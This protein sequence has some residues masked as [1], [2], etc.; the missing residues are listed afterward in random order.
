[1]K[2]DT[3]ARDTRIFMATDAFRTLIG[4]VAKQRRDAE[5]YLC[6]Q[7]PASI[8]PARITMERQRIVDMKRF[9]KWFDQLSE[10]LETEPVDD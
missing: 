8:D 5:S 7:Q 1:M 4:W 3:I 10:D 6:D 9:T 2:L